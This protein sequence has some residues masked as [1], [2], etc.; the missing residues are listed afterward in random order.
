MQRLHRRPVVLL[1]G[2]LL[3]MLGVTNSRVHGSAD[4]R[5]VVRYVAGDFYVAGPDLIAGAVQASTG[6]ATAPLGWF[7]FTAIDDDAVLTVDDEGPLGSVP[8]FVAHGGVHERHCVPNHGSLR[9]GGLVP[10]ERVNV[11]IEAA[12]WSYGSCGVNGGGT[13]G[14]AT[15]TR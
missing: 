5:T 3:T 1:V 15:V 14:R 12:T 7:E 8:V 11:W 10:G 4:Q 9:I 2:L 6:V 13:V